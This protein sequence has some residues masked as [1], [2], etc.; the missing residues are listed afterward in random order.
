M[1]LSN[2]CLADSSEFISI[3]EE[4]GLVELLVKVLRDRTEADLLKMSLSAMENILEYGAEA[5]M[6]SA[7]SNLYL[8]KFEK[9]GGFEAINKLKSYSDDEVQ[10]AAAKIEEKYSV[11]E[12]YF[13]SSR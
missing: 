9:F 8:E 4:Y 11:K 10:E 5:K 12:L 1:S 2:A 7:N 3:L 6:N 13:V